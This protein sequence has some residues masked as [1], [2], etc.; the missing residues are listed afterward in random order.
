[1]FSLPPPEWF[2][3]LS[4]PEDHIDKV[5][6]KRKIKDTYVET[7][8]LNIGDVNLLNE[9]PKM[10]RKKRLK[11]R[12]RKNEE[13]E[14]QLVNDSSVVEKSVVEEVC[15]SDSEELDLALPIQQQV[16]KLNSIVEFRMNYG[17]KWVKF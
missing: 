16:T 1:M 17:N 7:Q 9:S 10:K 8:P 14:Q 4:S 6:R 12:K 5:Q 2:A 11:K 3:E 15:I 13:T